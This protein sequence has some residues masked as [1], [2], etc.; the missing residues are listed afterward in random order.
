[1]IE[2]IEKQRQVEFQETFQ[3]ETQTQFTDEI[4]FNEF[5]RRILYVL[6][7]LESKN[8]AT[9]YES[10]YRC[11][12]EFFIDSHSTETFSRRLRKLAELNVVNRVMKEGRVYFYTNVLVAGQ[13]NFPLVIREK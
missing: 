9:R 6:K 7:H 8:A 12:T 11:Y 1:M 4:E 2:I 5:T 13:E 10:I 3:E